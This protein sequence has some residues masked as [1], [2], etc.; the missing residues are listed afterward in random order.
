MAFSGPGSTARS[1]TRPWLGLI[2][3]ATLFLGTGCSLLGGS[4]SSP[5]TGSNNA[6]L[7][8]STIRVGAISAISSAPLYIAL[9][10]G[11]FSQQ[12]LDVQPVVTQGGAQAIP[13]LLSGGLDLTLTNDMTA[14]TAQLKKTADLRFVFDGIQ[15]AKDTYT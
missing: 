15:T 13:Q 9:Q 1:R 12:G 10:K 6:H 3:V 5:S 8:K 11:Y 7:E 4:S 14:I 2:V